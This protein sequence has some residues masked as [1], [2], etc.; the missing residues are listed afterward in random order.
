MI[1][2]TGT[3]TWNSQD[4]PAATGELRT[5]SRNW[6]GANSLSFWG[7]DN[8]S[9]DATPVLGALAAGDTIHIEQA[10]NTGNYSNYSVTGAATQNA[11]TSWLVPVNRVNGSGQASNG[12]NIRVML[13]VAA[14]PVSNVS[15]VANIVMNPAISLE[16]YNAFYTALQAFVDRYAHLIQSVTYDTVAPVITTVPVLSG[17]TVVAATTAGDFDLTNL[18]IPDPRPKSV[19][20]APPGQT[21]VVPMVSTTSDTQDWRQA[22][23]Q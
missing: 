7:Q 4:P 21:S 12:Q 19:I 6:S 8:A 1:E 15:I 18:A 2:Y 11:D 20:V 23:G 10:N 22:K 17:M 5:E 14:E 9:T 3:W 13:T 16:R